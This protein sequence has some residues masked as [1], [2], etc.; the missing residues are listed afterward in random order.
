[1]T[2]HLF[3]QRNRATSIT[4]VAVLALVALLVAPSTPAQAASGRPT[5]VLAQGAGMGVHPSAQVRVVQRALDRRDYDLGAPGVD[6]RFGPLTEAAVRRMQADYGLA[7]DG[8]VGR[9]TR[10]A[11]GLARHVRT[12]APSAAKHRSK[13]IHEHRPASARHANGGTSA[14]RTAPHIASPEPGDTAGAWVYLFV[15]GLIA[16]LSALAVPT[17]RRKRE[18]ARAT[19]TASPP[20]P[21]EQLRPRSYDGPARRQTMPPT[22]NGNGTGR[23]SPAA[24]AVRVPRPL[25]PGDRV[26]GYLTVS[27]D[28][29]ANEDD[30]SAAAIKAMCERSG[31]QLL[32]IVRD[33][34]TGVTL[35]RPGLGY[36]LKRIADHQAAG[37][38]V[39]DLRR[40]SRSIVDLGAL[41][42]W[43]RDAR[44]TLVALDLDINTSTPKGQQVASTL[45]ALSAHKNQQIAHRIRNGVANA[46]SGGRS[47]GRPAVRHDPE[48]QERI[49][50]MR[51]ANMTLQ[52][53]ADRLNAEGVPT[54]RGGVKWRPSSIQSALG[55]RRP[56][57]RDHLPS[58]EHR[59]AQA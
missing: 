3:A 46:P 13:A 25:G 4:T 56:A 54:L 6:G 53:I 2:I 19:T 27:A 8:I 24:G 5:P 22:P 29:R 15:A 48:L 9:H 51:A 36:A 11:L 35:E 12:E 58:L 14:G 55:Y 10:K 41:M 20:P 44:A 45:I 7:V 28:A 23:R 57:P 47:N 52:A 1:M 50:A 30:R 40:L 16:L 37:L 33:R 59:G 26:I 32:D 18:P 38:V 39:S 42:A 43:F 17:L 21:A 49:A 31:W 34:D